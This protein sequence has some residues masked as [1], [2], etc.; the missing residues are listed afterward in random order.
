M[1]ANRHFSLKMDFVWYVYSLLM[2]V[3]F[4]A[5]KCGRHLFFQQETV[6]VVETCEIQLFIFLKKE[7]VVV[8]EII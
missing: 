7:A 8:E 1:F 2:I 3:S 5:I 6:V 4:D